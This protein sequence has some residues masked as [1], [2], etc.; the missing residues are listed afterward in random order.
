MMRSTPEEG[1]RQTFLSFLNAGEFR[2]PY[3]A[4]CARF[5]YPPGRQ[6]PGCHP[7]GLEWRPMNGQGRV[8][9]ATVARHRPEEGG[10]RSIVMVELAEGPRML[11][12]IVNGKPDQVRIGAAVSA[13]IETTEMGPRVVFELAGANES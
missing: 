2:L 1:A 3:C 5:V 10:D 7:E 4:Q 11:S 12:T 9:A 8:Y 13:A 6:L